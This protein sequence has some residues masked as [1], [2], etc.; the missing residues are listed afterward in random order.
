MHVRMAYTVYATLLAMHRLRVSNPGL[1]IV[2]MITIAHAV[3]RQVV[4]G[5]GVPAVL[6]FSKLK[7]MS[8]GYF[9]PEK[10]LLDHKNK[11][12]LGGHNR[13]FVYQRS[14]AFQW[15][16]R[17]SLVASGSFLAEISVSSPRKLFVFIIKKT[18]SKSKYTKG[19]SFNFEKRSTDIR[20]GPYGPIGRQAA[21]F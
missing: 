12:F 10:F 3:E 11:Y 21:V 14:S 7:K 9:D 17:A 15:R 6:L 13:Y 18:F 19:V 1:H 16:M 5:L 8:F 2:T 20:S 4:P